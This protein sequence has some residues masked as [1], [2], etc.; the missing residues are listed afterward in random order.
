MLVLIVLLSMSH[1]DTRD[2]LA[3]LT[4]ACTARAGSWRL[5][6]SGTWQSVEQGHRQ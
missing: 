4:V 6:A 2:A 1:K 3:Q 5:V